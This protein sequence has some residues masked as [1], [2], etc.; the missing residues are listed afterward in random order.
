MGPTFF[1]CY[2]TNVCKAWSVSQCNAILRTTFSAIQNHTAMLYYDEH[3]Q[4]QK[5]TQHRTASRL[6]IGITKTICHR[7][8]YQTT[9]HL[10][11]NIQASGIPLS[12][13]HC[14]KY[15]KSTSAVRSAVPGS[16]NGSNS[17][18]L[19]KACKPVT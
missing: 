15:L 2:I 18:C 4:L 7:Q 11:Q 14:V 12:A 17:W 13:T 8:L 19:R 16:H 6:L 5:L 1:K 3:K 9:L 10:K